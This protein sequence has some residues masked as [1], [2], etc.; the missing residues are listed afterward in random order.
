M[1]R[2][3]EDRTPRCHIACPTRPVRAIQGFAEISKQLLDALAGAVVAFDLAV[4]STGS[5]VE[6]DGLLDLAAGAEPGRV[7]GRGDELGAG[8]VEVALAR[9]LGGQ[10]EASS[11]T[12]LACSL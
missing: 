11:P 6:G 7:L 5:G 8:Q 9:P 1:S 12:A 4:P 3:A 2:K 10:A